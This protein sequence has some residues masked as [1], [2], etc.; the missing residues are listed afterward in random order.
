MRLLT[1]DNYVTNQGM[2]VDG[3]RCPS[4]VGDS[5]KDTLSYEANKYWTAL[6]KAV[7]DSLVGKTFSYMYDDFGKKMFVCTMDKYIQGSKEEIHEDIIGGSE[8]NANIVTA[9]FLA[10][11]LGSSFSGTAGNISAGI[12]S[13]TFTYVVSAAVY[14]AFISPEIKSVNHDN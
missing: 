11:L 14:S 8:R 2:K 6:K 12:C 7:N 4:L 13:L 3:S 1:I 5:L 9:V 10:S